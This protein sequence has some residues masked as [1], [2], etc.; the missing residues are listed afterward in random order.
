MMDFMMPLVLMVAI[1]YLLL[2][3]PQKKRE[4]QAKDMRSNLEVGDE[5]LTVG[6]ILGRVVNMRDDSI[7]IESG[8]AN[9]KL[10]IT[11]TAVQANLTAQERMQERQQAAAAAAA[12]AKG[13]KK[14]EKTGDAKDTDAQT[15]AAAQEREKELEKKMEQE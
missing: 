3:R 10:R 12:E 15:M 9:T 8:S 7:L 2:I 1:F 13:K 6:G 14:S 11:K 4:K 5:I